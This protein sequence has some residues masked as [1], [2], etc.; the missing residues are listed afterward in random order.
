MANVLLRQVQEEVCVK[1]KILLELGDEAT[2][3]RISK[4]RHVS[5]KGQ[6]L[7]DRGKMLLFSLSR[8]GGGGTPL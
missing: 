8:E 6:H 1:D 4:F 3:N 7:F 5:L 2:E